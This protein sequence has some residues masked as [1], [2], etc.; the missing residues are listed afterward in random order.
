MAT[1]K[2]L[3]QKQ[4]IFCNEYLK[5]MSATQAAIKA[6]YS[7]KT[8]RQMGAENLT[9]PVIK[10]YIAERQIFIEKEAELTREKLLD[11][12]TNIATFDIRKLY[13][14]D[15][16]LIPIHELDDKTAAAIC[17]IEHYEEIVRGKVKGHTKKVKI[18]NALQAMD[19][20]GK[21]IGAFEADNGQ[22]APVVNTNI[23][24]SHLTVDEL[25]ELKYGKLTDDELRTMAAIEMKLAS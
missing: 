24:L 2:G 3:N 16:T 9:K 10:S 17:S 20:I 4:L 11:L 19:A 1:G 21:I 22:R 6:G 15:G 14:P 25:K 18:L 13:R 8:A 5:G 23:D 7:Q 12:Y